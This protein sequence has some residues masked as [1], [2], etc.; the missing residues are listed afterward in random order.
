MIYKRGVLPSIL[1]LSILTLAACSTNID[2]ILSGA[3]HA[4]GKIYVEGYFSDTQGEVIIA[5][6]PSNWTPEQLAELC[7]NE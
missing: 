7:S 6:A 1:L 5:K 3:S 4:C 2:K